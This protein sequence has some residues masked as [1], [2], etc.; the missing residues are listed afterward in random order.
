[1]DLDLVREIEAVAA[2][3]W[4]ALETRELDGWL[5]RW[6][7]GV[8]LR[9]NSVLA[10]A[11]GTMPMDARLAA[12]EAFYAA[13]QFPP[14]FQVCAASEPAGLDDELARLGWVRQTPTEVRIASVDVVATHGRDAAADIRSGWDEAWFETW[15]AL[16][17]VDEQRADVIRAMLRAVSLP[18]GHATLVVDGRNVAVGRAVVDGSWLGIFNMV[19]SAG[20][21]RRG[22]ATAVLGALARWGAAAGATRAYLQVDA[23]NAAAM[24]LYARTGFRLAYDYWYRVRR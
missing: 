9:A 20:W 8:T 2:H 1:M 13:H 24:A 21:R 19:T 6:S 22:A 17:E 4:P 12:V 11:R 15:R 14:A 23:G 16:L 18:A 7:H 5:L 10:G 3:S